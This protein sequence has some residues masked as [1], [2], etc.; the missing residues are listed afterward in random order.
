MHQSLV[1]VH[2]LLQVYRLV[3]IV[4]KGG[5][6]IEVLIGLDDVLG[7]NGSLDHSCAEDAAS[8][9]AAIG[10]EVDVGIEITLYLGQRLAY[11]CDV[12]MLERLIDT[13]VVDT[14]REVG[15]GARLL[16]CTSRTRDGVDVAPWRCRP[17]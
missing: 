10:Y 3:C 12:L 5:I 1:G 6:A 13:Q 9:V 7:R 15:G 2:H 11:L 14:P 17:C 4:G 16:T 8:E